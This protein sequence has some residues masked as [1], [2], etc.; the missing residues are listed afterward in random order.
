MPS[1][2]A[3]PRKQKDWPFASAL[4]PGEAGPTNPVLVTKRAFLNLAGLL[5]IGVLLSAQ[6]VQRHG[7]VFE[8]WV[9]GTFFGGYKPESY[10]QRWDIP[11]AEN[12][13]HGGIP[14][15]PKAVKY[16]TAV[17]LGDALR[18]YEIDEPFLLIVG[19]WQQDGDVKRVV[20][21]L[22]PKVS[23]ELWRRLW[24]PVTYSDLLRL[25]ALI[26]DTGPSV[27]ET[28][29]LALRMKNSPPF[30]AAVIQVNPKIDT[31][32]Q[33]RL[34]CSIR[35]KDFFQYLAPAANPQPQEHPALFGVE[36]PGPIAS[37][38]RDLRQP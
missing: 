38:S 1:S 35:F 23:P 2:F 29:R 19:F 13:A 30:T 28:R 32:G 25:D 18:Q 10:T 22:A 7:L 20:N 12:K 33:R 26:K 36:Y 15:N 24:G 37:E 14:V 17:D 8:A 4:W 21:I 5:A 3:R 16:G 31:R 27:E 6:E 9:R 11:A 34:Q